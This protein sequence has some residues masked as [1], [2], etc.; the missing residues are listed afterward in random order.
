VGE[1]MLRELSSGTDRG[2]LRGH[3]N[4][5]YSV[6]FSPDG[7]LLASGGWDGGVK[8]WDVHELRELATFSGHNDI[9]LALA[10]SPDG[11]V[12]ASGGYDQTVRVWEVSET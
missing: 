8:L 10:F 2:V 5:A 3:E 11:K 12:L 9:V 7:R 6:A 1:V 4:W